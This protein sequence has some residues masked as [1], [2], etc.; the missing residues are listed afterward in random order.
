MVVCILI[1]PCLPPPC[2]PSGQ[3][4]FPISYQISTSICGSL[5]VKGL[6]WDLL[7]LW[8]TTT[9][10][11]SKAS[12]PKDITINY[13]R[14]PLSEIKL[15]ALNAVK[16]SGCQRKTLLARRLMK[17]TSAENGRV[18]RLNKTSI[19]CNL[20]ILCINQENVSGK[21][22]PVGE[23][24]K[25][26]HPF[27]L[28]HHRPTSLPTL[29]LSPLTQQQ[30]SPSSGEGGQLMR[31]FQSGACKNL[32]KQISSPLVSSTCKVNPYFS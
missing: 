32:I 20:I 21:D 31:S 1:G 27:P 19:L 29:P 15:S 30:S 23:G 13:C 18:S 7:W 14:T 4:A 6:Q 9:D 17:R 26:S 5:T 28:L 12:L 3:W 24:L 22:S 8:V 16:V 10:S 25:F 2:V 11:F